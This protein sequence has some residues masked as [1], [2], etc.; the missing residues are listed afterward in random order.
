MT[1][2]PNW[3]VSTGNAG[4]KYLGYRRLL[5][6]DSVPADY[7][8]V[9]RV[10]R[11]RTG[12]PTIPGS[13][14]ANQFSVSE[15]SLDDCLRKYLEWIRDPSPEVE[16]VLVRISQLDNPVVLCWCRDAND[17]HAKIVV[18]EVV[19]RRVQAE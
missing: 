16:A 19:C 8:Y 15:Y 1:S 4:A 17:C 7:V 3:S 13:V 11:D 18:N 6:N 10:S 12:G 2:S 9:G 5:A 14:L